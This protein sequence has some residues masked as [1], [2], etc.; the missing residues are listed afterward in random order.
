MLVS[1]TRNVKMIILVIE[2]I[3]GRELI[4]KERDMKN[5]ETIDYER[6]KKEFIQHYTEEFFQY[7]H[8]MLL[9]NTR[10]MWDEVFKYGRLAIEAYAY[11]VNMANDSV[12][13]FNLFTT[14]QLKYEIQGLLENIVVIPELCG[15]EYKHYLEDRVVYNLYN[16]FCC[17]SDRYMHVSKYDEY[18]VRQFNN[19]VLQYAIQWNYQLAQDACSLI[20]QVSYLK[21]DIE[22]INNRLYLNG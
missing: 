18:P 15:W 16:L 5:I 17:L 9:N 1:C 10:N 3:N 12:N 7:Y 2:K 19:N 22:E 8:K 21:T 13:Y 6:W 4:I 11:I 20:K 14:G